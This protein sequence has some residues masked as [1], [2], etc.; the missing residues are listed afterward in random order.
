MIGSNHRNFPLK[1]KSLWLFTLS[2]WQQH[3]KL[4][5]FFDRVRNSSPGNVVILKCVCANY[6]NTSHRTRIFHKAVYH[7]FLS[8]MK[9]LM[10]G[11]SNIFHVIKVLFYRLKEQTLEINLNNRFKTYHGEQNV[12]SYPVHQYQRNVKLHSQVAFFMRI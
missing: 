9:I 8:L 5:F 4:T 12:L 7:P 1:K 3:L 6:A 10:L 11:S 2:L